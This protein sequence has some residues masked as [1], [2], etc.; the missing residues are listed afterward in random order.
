MFFSGA[1]GAIRI[2]AAGRRG[3]APETE[4]L[5]DR[6]GRLGPARPAGR[7]ARHQFLELSRRSLPIDFLPTYIYIYIYIYRE[8]LILI[9]Y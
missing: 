6:P 9:I 5:A 1:L 7:T 2:R 4:N 8:L 3:G